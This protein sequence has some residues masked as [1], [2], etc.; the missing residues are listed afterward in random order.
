MS[1]DKSA[2]LSTACQERFI[3][4]TYRAPAGKIRPPEDIYLI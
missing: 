1:A 2:H 3:L 4:H